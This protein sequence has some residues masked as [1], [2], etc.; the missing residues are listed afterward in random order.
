MQ[1]VPTG[2]ELR[3][4]VVTPNTVEMLQGNAVRGTAMT[5]LLGNCGCFPEST[6]LAF[7]PHMHPEELAG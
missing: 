4:T 3:T 2:G 1:M 6:P 5:A 7:V